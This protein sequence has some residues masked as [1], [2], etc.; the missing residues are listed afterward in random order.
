MEN[1]CLLYGITQFT[2]TA[3]AHYKLN[4][5]LIIREGSLSTGTR[6]QQNT[7]KF[8][9]S[10]WLRLLF[11]V[12]RWQRSELAEREGCNPAISGKIFRAQRHTWTSLKQAERRRSNLYFSTKAKPTFF[13]I[14]YASRFS[15]P[16]ALINV[17]PTD[18]LREDVR[19][20]GVSEST[21][22]SIY[23]GI[24]ASQFLLVMSRL[25]NLN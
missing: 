18:S 11:P 1:Y 13:Y 25:R 19:N 15:L 7:L 21:N 20:L 5:T 14:V 3:S 2:E 22:A 4:I 24:K 6:V 16:L 12:Q 8:W 17:I 23:I 9:A 10:L